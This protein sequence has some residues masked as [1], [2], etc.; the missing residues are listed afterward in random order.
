[1]TE[2]APSGPVGTLLSGGGLGLPGLPAVPGIPTV[3]D[4]DTESAEPGDQPRL[5][6]SLGEVRQAVK[7]H[8]AA[9]RVVSVHIELVS[10]KTGR[11]KPG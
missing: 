1:M 2:S 9:A 11:S 3:N 7:G 4:G 10:A 5:R 6:L 8:A